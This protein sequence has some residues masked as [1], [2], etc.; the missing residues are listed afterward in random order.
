MAALTDINDAR[1]DLKKYRGGKHAAKEFFGE[2]MQDKEVR[3][4]NSPVHVAD[5]IKVPVFL[6]HGDLDENVQFDQFTR[7]KKALKKANVDA[8][9]MTFKDE[10]HFLSNQKNREDFFIG[11]DKFLTKVNGT[12]EYMK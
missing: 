1:R 10:D 11:V 12:S 6:A 3:K 4:A 7:M 8:T 9:Y 5:Q 2:A